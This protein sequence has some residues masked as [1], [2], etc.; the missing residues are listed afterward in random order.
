M[1]TPD[2]DAVRDSH[3]RD[4]LEAIITSAWKEEMGVDDLSADDDFYDLG[5]HSLMEIRLLGKLAKLRLP[6]RTQDIRE[7]R[8]VRAL[9]RVLAA[10][11]WP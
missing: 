10:R 2:V 5:G 7:A 9:A 6:V 8:T 4:Q 11:G 1:S 3:R